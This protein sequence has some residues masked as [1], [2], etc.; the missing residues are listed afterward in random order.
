MVEEDEKEVGFCIAEEGTDIY[1]NTG[2]V[3]CAG[4]GIVIDTSSFHNIHVAEAIRHVAEGLKGFV[5]ATTNVITEVANILR[6]VMDSLVDFA[7][8][9]DAC[10]KATEKDSYPIV[11]STI[12]HPFSTK[13]VRRKQRSMIRR[14][15]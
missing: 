2:I 13:P 4:R 8:K 5:I 6:P 11:R 12:P 9:Y 7:R 15:C 14:T 10:L 1:L 3:I